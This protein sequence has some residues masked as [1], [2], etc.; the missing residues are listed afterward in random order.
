MT[1]FALSREALLG[2]SVEVLAPLGWASYGLWHQLGTE[3]IVKLARRGADPAEVDALVTEQWHTES[4]VFLRNVAVPLRRYG[5]DVDHQFQRLQFQRGNLIDQAVKCHKAGNYAAAT[6]LTLAQIDGLTRDITGATFFSNSTNDPYL[7]DSTLAGIATNLP[8]VREPFKEKVA[9]TGFY[10]KLSRHGAAHGRDLSFGT[11]VTST[12]SL[13][14][15]GA[16]VEYLEERAAKVAKKYRKQREIEAQRQSGTDGNGR[17][18]DD[19]HLDQLY[20][21]AADLDSHILSQA[22]LPFAR[23]E[24]WPEKAHELIEQRMLS[25]R[26]F[27]WGGVDATSY[28]WSYRTPAGRHLGAAARRYGSGLPLDWRQWRWDDTDPPAG[29]PW[30]HDGWAEYD[31]NNASPNWTID[32]LPTG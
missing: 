21:L 13:V 17:L 20:F 8:I 7:D 31:G 26:S 23:P 29:A 27:T 14:L 15:M 4:E 10:G 9:L 28:W 3:Q 5:K 6:L 24:S 2:R 18:N 25:R 32:P 11:K 30:D 12:K 22:I 1:Y 19:R 16:L